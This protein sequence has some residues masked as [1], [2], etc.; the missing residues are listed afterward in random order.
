MLRNKLVRSDGSVIDS[1][2][3]I[4]CEFTEEVNSS[5]NLAV[6]CITASELTVEIRSTEAIQQGEVFTYYMVEDGVEK[7]IGKFIAEKP[8]VAS[9]T[10]NRFSAY[11]NIVKTEKIFSEWLIENQGLFPMTLLNLVKQACSY[12]G[13]T[14]ATEDFPNA[15]LSIGAFYADDLPCRQIISWAA[16]IAGRFVRAN[17]DGAIEFAWYK[18]SPGRIGETGGG[19]AGSNILLNDDGFGNVSI[20]SEDITF[21]DDGDGNVSVQAKGITLIDDGVGNVELLGNGGSSGGVLYFADSLSYETYT[22]DLIERVQIKHSET[23]VGTIYPADATGNCFTISENML[24]G[25]C[26]SEVVEGVAKGLYERLNAVTYVP[27]SVTIP[28]TIVVRAGDI[29]TVRDPNG[30]TFSTFVMKLRLSPSGVSLESTGDKCYDTSVAVASE[31]Y[32]NLTGKILSIKKSV[33]GLE[34]E[35]ADLKG[36]VSSIKATTDS[37]ETTVR[38]LSEDVDANADSLKELSTSFTQTKSEFEMQFTET[39]TSLDSLNQNVE[40]L[41]ASI[42]FVDGNIVL[43]RSSS[44]IALTIKSDR[45][46][47]TLGGNEVAYI[48]NNR[49]Y[50]TDGE[51]L[52]YLYIGKFAFTPN[53][54]GNLSFRKVR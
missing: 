32:S 41:T 7:L 10:T 45:I 19:S 23:D 14:L 54:N 36:S 21:T 50:I 2:V 12:C 18:E 13:V 52:Q 5:T 53:D 37:I 6:G 30:N 44:D 33:E 29:V 40:E 11:D 48:S 31:R 51:F 47:F 38:G 46:S 4:S 3:I 15:N 22:T 1:S 28:R 27:F 17:A 25:T 43:S 26:S 9:R 49:L 16:A 34:I 39:N 42:R 8:T 35:N 20:E 24:I